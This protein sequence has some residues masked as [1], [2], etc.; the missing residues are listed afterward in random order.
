MDSGSRKFL[1]I[2]LWWDI[3]QQMLHVSFHLYLSQKA[4]HNWT[5][6][7]LIQFTTMKDSSYWWD[8][9]DS[10]LLCFPNRP[11]KSDEKNEHNECSKNIP[12]SALT[13]YESRNIV[14]VEHPSGMDL[15]KAKHKLERV[16]TQ[17]SFSYAKNEIYF[18]FL[19][20]LAAYT[21]GKSSDDG[22]EGVD[23]MFF[24]LPLSSRIVGQLEDGK[25]F[26]NFFSPPIL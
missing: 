15:G 24:S 21:K 11:H 3:L 1:L 26:S 13:S 14:L 23:W 10:Y 19:L 5:M 8:F 9:E 18:F 16:E 17:K 20:F 25:A 12:L 2:D 22:I 6:K 4:S 7:T